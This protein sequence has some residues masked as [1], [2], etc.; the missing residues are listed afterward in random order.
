MV[1]AAEYEDSLSSSYYGDT[2]NISYLLPHLAPL[3]RYEVEVRLIGSGWKTATAHF[4]TKRAE[5][6]N[7]QQGLIVA[8]GTKTTNKVSTKSFHG[9]PAQQ[10]KP[11]PRLSQ[12]GGYVHGS[13]SSMSKTAVRRVQVHA[14]AQAKFDELDT[15][16]VGVLGEEPVLQLSQWIW[17]QMI[18]KGV[19]LSTEER[20]E[21]EARL[22][23][24]V[25][26]DEDRLSNSQSA[27]EMKSGRGELDFGLFAEWF[28]KACNRAV[29]HPTRVGIVER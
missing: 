12:S 22:M 1:E 2:G 4:S 21:E 18:P 11:K 5:P 6:K 17:E 23:K 16:H 15:E 28:E 8:S 24:A 10:T 19:P 27:L 29:V 9:K 14:L 13:A 20:K 7:R 25:E 3:T 26:S